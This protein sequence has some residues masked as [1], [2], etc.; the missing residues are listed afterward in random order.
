MFARRASWAALFATVLL[1]GA[2]DWHPAGEPPHALAPH[3]GVIYFPSAS[4]PG[5]PTHL[6]AAKAAERPVCPACLH[7]LR[8]GG[9]HLRPAAA[10]PP[11]DPRAAAAPDRSLPRALDR[12]RPR[13]ARGPP[14]FS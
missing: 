5:Q 4:H 13:G 7:Q 12:R 3:T 6:E 11:P 14:S 10:L 8:T 9:A 2:I 1:L